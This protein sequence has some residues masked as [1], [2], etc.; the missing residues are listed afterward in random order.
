MLLIRS[1]SQVNLDFGSLS[2]W[3]HLIW[4]YFPSSLV[5]QVYRPLSD[6]NDCLE[7]SPFWLYALDRKRDQVPPNHLQRLAIFLLFRFS[8]NLISLKGTTSDP[9]AC[10]DPNTCLI[11][12]FNVAPN[13]CSR[14]RGLLELHRWL[15]GQLHDNIFEDSDMYSTRCISFATSFL[16]LYIHEDD[17]LFKMLLQLFQVPVYADRW[18]VITLQN[19][20]TYSL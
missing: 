2:S 8:F 15:Q 4:K 20:L 16:R 13:C 5:Q 7:D 6:L 1:T 11:I 17:V 14:R 9:C 18:C 19:F 3:L 12:D 10:S